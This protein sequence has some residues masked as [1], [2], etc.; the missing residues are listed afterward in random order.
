VN[1]SFR[2]LRATLVGGI[3]FLVPLI[4]VVF[5]IG[6]ALDIAARVVEPLAA[7]LPAHSV[8]GLSTPVFLAALLIFLFCMLSGL[9]ART[10]AAR[11]IVAWLEG[12][13]L[14]SVP[15][16][17]FL[18]NVG[19][20]VLGVTPP[21]MPPAVLV[22]FDDSWQLAFVMDRLADGR[23]TVYV[24][25]APNP[26]S[27]AVHVVTADRIEALAMSPAAALK[28]LGRLGGGAGALLDPLPK[29]PEGALP[30]GIAGGPLKGADD[31]SPSPSTVGFCATRGE[32]LN[33]SLTT[34]PQPNA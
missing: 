6:K 18:K 8:I 15:G 23:V 28:C 34:S 33:A 21:H 14:T 13:V 19:Q 2:F 30:T 27:G 24:P 9:F 31:E 26:Y 17:E 29:P 7:A 20:T 4:L 16:Y 10:R 22:R 12:G 11:R 25:T 3:L 5:V 1:R 32:S